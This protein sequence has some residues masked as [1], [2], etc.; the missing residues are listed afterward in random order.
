VRGGKL[1]RYLVLGWVWVGGWFW[2]LYFQS[3]SQSYVTPLVSLQRGGG[4]VFNSALVIRLFC[5]RLRC[6]VVLSLHVHVGMYTS[7]TDQPLYYVILFSFL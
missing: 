5:S 6:G 7:L 1:P 3:V 4:V 2:V